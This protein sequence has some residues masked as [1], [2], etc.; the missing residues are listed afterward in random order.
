[1]PCRS[2]VEV[3]TFRRLDLGEIFTIAFYDHISTYNSMREVEIG[4][5]IVHERSALKK[6]A[7]QMRFGHVRRHLAA[8][9]MTLLS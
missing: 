3:L 9:T 2:G 8:A 4:S 1:M 7:V 6:M 5:V